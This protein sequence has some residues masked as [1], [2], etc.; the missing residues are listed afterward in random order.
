MW[1]RQCGCSR[2]FTLS[3]CSARGTGR[4][5][6]AR[7]TMAADVCGPGLKPHG[8]LPGFLSRCSHLGMLLLSFRSVAEPAGSG[9]CAEFGSLP[10][11]RSP[12]AGLRCSHTVVPGAEV[13]YHLSSSSKQAQPQTAN[14]SPL[15]CCFLLLSSAVFLRSI[16][17]AED[18]Y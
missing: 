9:P 2:H 12:A 7:P 13:F 15:S 4:L 6:L 10:S 1:P 8:G 16:Q 5:S 14:P 17:G 18:G 11:I 3:L